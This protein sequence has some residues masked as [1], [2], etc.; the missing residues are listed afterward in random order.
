MTTAKPP[1]LV[2]LQLTG[3]NDY[4]NTVIP[5]SEPLYYDN[6][7]S[8]RIAQE[9]VLRID[10]R[11]GFHPSMAAIKPFWDEGKM[12]II[13]GIG[14]PTPNYSHFRSMDI[15]YTAEPDK[16]SADGW[17]G[18]V[19][20][21][22]DPKAEN[23]LT[24][25]NFGR[26]LPRAL[27]LSG[28]PVA[29]VAQLDNY[30][31]L[32]SLSGVDQRNSALEIFSSMY[33]D[34]FNDDNNVKQLKPVHPEDRMGEVLRYMGQ[35]GLDAQKGADILS[36]SLGK[37]SSTVNYPNSQIAANLKGIA[38]VK[39]AGLGTRVFYTSH[40]SF[41]THAAELSAHAL[42]WK[43][44]SEAVSAFFADLREHDAADDVIMLMWSEFGRR[45]R[46]N[47][48][49]TDHGAGG[50]A[51]LLG[52]PVKGGMYGEYPS[53]K[54]NDLTIGNLQFNNDFRSTYSSILERWMEVD[55][56]PIVNGSFEQFAFV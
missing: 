56:K 50:V 18:K 16:M 3:G 47:G 38:Q 42:L 54:E 32:T 41:D 4:L 11:F 17:L 13:N 51:F 37:Y 22:I 20:Q 48:A 25:V 39:L 43:D 8:V 14:Y 55:A 27:A 40:A 46:D 23:V 49:G 28:V 21:D 1:I 52:D 30:G 31:L 26:G 12:A 10:D 45:V 44:V 35:T 9:D 6:R 34:G 24:A 53:L 36:T 2:V 29:S 19:V 33:D 15:W 7:K 5:Y